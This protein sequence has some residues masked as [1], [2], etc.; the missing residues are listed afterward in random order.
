M[1]LCNEGWLDGG[2]NRW[3]KKGLGGGEG[4]MEKVHVYDRLGQYILIKVHSVHQINM[5]VPTIYCSF[6]SL[7]FLRFNIPATPAAA[8]LDT[9]SLLSL[10]QMSGVCES[11]V[12]ECKSDVCKSGVCESGV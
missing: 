7:L 3:K 5:H 1:Q 6:S 11:G 4:R 2:R 8:P 9:K 10:Q 12:C